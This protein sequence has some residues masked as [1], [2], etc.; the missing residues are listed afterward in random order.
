MFYS[1]FWKVIISTVITFWGVALSYAATDIEALN[2]MIIQLNERIDAQQTNSNHIWTMTAAALVLFMQLG[3]LLLE[4]GMVRSK[5]SINVAQK[6][7]TDFIFAVCAFY[8]VGFALMF[9]PS[10]G[11]WYGASS[12][13]SSFDQIDDWSYTFFVFQAVFV[14]T[15]ATIVSGAVA[16]RMK[17]SCYLIMAVFLA[18]LIYPL[19]GHWAWGN[20]LIGDNTAWLADMGFIDFAGSTVVHSVGG[21]IALAG[22]IVLG[23]RKNRFDENG[24]PQAIQGHSMVLASAGAIILLVGWIGFNG[25][26]T[27]AGTPDFARVVA[28][29]IIAASVGG[30]VALSVGRFIDGLFLP[31]RSINGLLAALVGITAGAY[32]VNPQGAAMIGLISGIVVIAS[33]EFILRVLKLDDVVGAVSVHGVAGAVG[34]LLVAVFAAPEHLVAATR[35]DQFVVQFTG[36]AVGFAW[37]FGLGIIGFVLMKYTIGIRVHEH[38]EVEG[39]NA[40]EHGASLGTGELQKILAEMVQGKGDLSTRLDYEPGDEAAEISG[41]FNVLLDRLEKDQNTKNAEI[42]ERNEYAEKERETVSEI[43]RIISHARSGDLSNRLSVN[44]KTGVLLQISEGV[45]GLFDAMSGVVSDMKT[46]LEDMADGRLHTVDMEGSEGDFGAIRKAYNSSADAM[47]SVINTVSSSTSVIGETAANLDEA[48]QQ[49]LYRSEEQRDKIGFS[50]N[51]IGE[52]EATLSETVNRAGTAADSARETYQL[53]MQGSE[54]AGMAMELMEK[55]K[56][57]SARAKDFV[58]IIEEIAFQTNLLALNAA[59]EAARA[60]EAGSGF[61]VV[62]SEVRA[63][64]NRVSDQSG[65]ISQIMEENSALIGNGADFVSEVRESLERINTVAESSSTIVA[66]ISTS[67]GKDVTNLKEIKTLINEVEG[68]TNDTAADTQHTFE[69]VKKLKQFATELSTKVEHFEISEHSDQTR[70]AA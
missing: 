57:S 62:A 66:E 43:S 59:V 16:E 48:S 63:L 28:N 29:T 7:I 26:S 65:Q 33:E 35:W 68:L 3:F 38:E 31:V 47:G 17:F 58:S 69:A 8:F 13:L 24:K 49:A 12:S 41:L 54:K 39:L 42:M 45:N 50:N 56:A 6:N 20:L 36:V 5:N 30:F 40:A 51:R 46:S 53:S 64:A 21:W 14:G 1:I 44:D 11:G 55:I 60:G 23:A 70:S 37:A 34:T 67:A 9:G 15:A 2:Q 10:V 19:F 32:A 18:V 4:A 52:I 25:G 22:I 27:T 61:A